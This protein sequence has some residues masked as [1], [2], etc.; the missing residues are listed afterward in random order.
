[1]SVLSLVPTWAKSGK[2]VAMFWLL[3]ASLF[4]LGSHSCHL[5]LLGFLVLSIKYNAK[6]A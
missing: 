1:M 4:R 6:L 3:P 5:Y 2:P